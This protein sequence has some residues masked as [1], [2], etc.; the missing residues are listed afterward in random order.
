MSLQT[1]VVFFFRANYIR[2][3]FFPSVYRL[4]IHFEILNS[5]RLILREDSMKLYQK[6]ADGLAEEKI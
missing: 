4:C 2:S 3:D 1:I 5:K 6:T